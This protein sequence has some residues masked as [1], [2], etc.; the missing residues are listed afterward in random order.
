MVT[1]DSLFSLSDAVQ[2][3][4]RPHEQLPVGRG[5]VGFHVF[6]HFVLGDELI[7]GGRG[8]D[9][10]LSLL[11]AD[12]EVLTGPNNTSPQV[13]AETFFPD[14]FA[15]RDIDTLGDARGIGD[16]E[17]SVVN[18]SRTDPLRRLFDMPQ[19][20]RLRDIPRATEFDGHH[21]FE[22]TAHADQYAVADCGIGIIARP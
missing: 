19:A 8:E 4:I 15:G 2:I 7:L 16:V 1:I 17:V 20:M 11:V 3:L 10:N 6:A 13:A 21:R 5:D 14:G 12:V 18:D 9:E 22:K